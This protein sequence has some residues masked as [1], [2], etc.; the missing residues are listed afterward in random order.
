[1]PG[2]RP[3]ETPHLP[4]RR[5]VREILGPGVLIAVI[6]WYFGVDVWHAVL[7]GCAIPVIAL[8]LLVGSM[9]RDARDLSWRPGNRGHREGSR[10]DVANL[11]SSLR[12]G[13]GFVGL[14]ADRQLQQIAQRRLAIEGL[15]LNNVEHQSAIERRIGAEAYGVL[16]SSQGRVPTLGALVNCLD[17]LDAID[18]AQ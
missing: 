13:W 6:C 2:Q 11:S 17:A 4:H 1:M 5:A 9:A 3:N 15:D 18:S 12:G 14:T 8:A 16:V 7:L 10:T